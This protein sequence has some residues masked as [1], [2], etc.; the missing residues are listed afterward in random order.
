ML[1]FYII[2]IWSEIFFSNSISVSLYFYFKC[3]L[4]VK[5]QAL[6]LLSCDLPRLL[7]YFFITNSAEVSTGYSMSSVIPLF[8]IQFQLVK[9]ARDKFPEAN[10]R[11]WP[12]MD[13][14]NSL[15]VNCPWR[16]QQSKGFFRLVGKSWIELIGVGFPSLPY[17]YAPT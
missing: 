13:K 6:I 14:S 5:L 15:V 2:K 9:I 10:W 16:T 4:F 17:P 1:Y 11:K 3:L 12:R 7:L 8:I